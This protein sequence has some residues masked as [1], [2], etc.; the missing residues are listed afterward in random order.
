MNPTPEQIAESEAEEREAEAFVGAQWKAADAWLAAEWPHATDET[1]AAVRSAWTEQERRNAE[2]TQREQDLALL[3]KRLCRR[4]APED[5][6]CE[7]AL[8]YLRRAGLLGHPLRTHDASAKDC[9]CA[10]QRDCTGACC[11]PGVAVAHDQTV[12]PS[13]T[14]GSTK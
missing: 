5:M 9:D 12:S 8:E 11:T 3:V 4:L 2:P 6:L 13:P 10:D 7:G 1:R 14:D